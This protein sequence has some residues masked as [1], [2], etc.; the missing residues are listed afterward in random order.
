MNKYHP[1]LNEKIWK[2]NNS[3]KLSCE[4]KKSMLK[5]LFAFNVFESEFFEEPK[6]DESGK[7]EITPVRERIIKLQEF[8]KDFPMKYL[9]SF[10]SYFSSIYIENNAWT[11]RFK[12][13]RKDEYNKNGYD[14]EEMGYLYDFLTL[15]IDDAKNKKFGVKRALLLSYK[16]RN[17]LFH[18]E[19]DIRN[20][21]K[22]KEDF[23]EIASFLIKLMDYLN[24]VD[25]NVF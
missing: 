14:D 4:L 23:E 6:Y 1:Y 16:F 11:D 25:A 18:G 13:L 10:Q 8:C 17:N 9:E 5:F 2:I 15:P 12:T 19:K 20:L 3:N 22:Y 21:E 24:S 7:K